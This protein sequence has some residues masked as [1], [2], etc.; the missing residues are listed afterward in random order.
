M[1]VNIYGKYFNHHFLVKTP[2]DMPGMILQVQ[3][4]EDRQEINIIEDRNGN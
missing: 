2:V 3:F 1:H 4:Q